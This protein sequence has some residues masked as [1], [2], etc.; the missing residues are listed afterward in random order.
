MHFSKLQAQC[1]FSCLN[2]SYR[3][4][5]LSPLKNRVNYNDYM[6]VHHSKSNYHRY[7]PQSKRQH[8]EIQSSLPLSQDFSRFLW[9]SEVTQMNYSVFELFFH[10][11]SYKKCTHGFPY[12]QFDAIL[13]VHAFSMFLKEIHV[14]DY[15]SWTCEL[16]SYWWQEALCILCGSNNLWLL[17]H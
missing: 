2:L 12:I 13:H 5:I 14:G 8:P 7:I 1:L 10:L 15:G 17:F 4:T 9:K 6:P 16:Y 11:P 3:D